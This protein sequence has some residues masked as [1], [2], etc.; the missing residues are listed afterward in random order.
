MYAIFDLKIFDRQKFLGIYFVL[1][2]QIIVEMF[3]FTSGKACF[4]SVLY[5]P[6]CKAVTHSGLIGEIV[7]IE[8]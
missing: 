8:R 5:Y 1:K 6:C 2:I 4:K 7:D 3:F